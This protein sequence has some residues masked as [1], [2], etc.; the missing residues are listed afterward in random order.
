M[1]IAGKYNKVNKFTFQVPD[2]FK[3]KSLADLFNDNGEKHVYP[4]KAIY[5]NKKSRY[6]DAP[7]IATDECLV[8]V[9]SHMLDTVKEMLEDEELVNAVNDDKFG[10]TI[11]PYNTGRAK[12]TFY[13][14][15]WVDM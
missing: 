12:G 8:N 4:V 2:D 1:S 10:F 15:T 3:Y 5:I 11:Y 14:I 13:S 7:V 6:G 9:P